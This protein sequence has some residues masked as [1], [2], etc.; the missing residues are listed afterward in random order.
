MLEERQVVFDRRYRLPMLVGVS[1][2][3]VARHDA[4]IDFIEHDLSAKLN[5]RPALVPR[6]GTRVRLK[7]TEYLL[8]GGDFLAFEYTAAGLH[9]HLLDEG[10]HL[11]RL[12]R[13]PPG[14]LLAALPQVLQHPGGLLD[15]LFRRLHQFLVELLLLGFFVF[16]FAPQLSMEDLSGLTGGPQSRA[17]ELLRLLT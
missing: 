6:D 7:E 5:Q 16:A 12:L 9:D 1:Q 14:L 13:Q 8:L 10:E 15:H 2:D 4:P 11:L 3:L 17:T